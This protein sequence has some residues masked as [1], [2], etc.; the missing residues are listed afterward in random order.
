MAGSIKGIIVEIGGDTSG[1]QKALKQVN[2]TTS[3]LSK[4]LK[5]IN[6][7]LKLD[8]KNTE[9]LAQKQAVLSQNIQETTN[10]LN[11]LKQAQ[12]LADDTIKNG[13]T[14]SQEN[15]RNLQ[16]EIINTENKLKQLKV[17][18]SNWT[19]VSK[20][21]D[22]ISKKMKTV[23]DS[24]S[25]LGSS[26]TTG[27]TVPT[28]GLVG[29]ATAVGNKFEA[30]MSRV[31]SIAGATG[32][33]LKSL[34]DQALELGAQTSFSASEAAEGMENLASAGFTTKEIM[35]A[36][37][38]LLD[39]AA[40]SGS[41]L[42]TA[43]EI[44]ASAIR[45]F[46]LDASEAGHVADVFAEAAARTNAQTED[47][48]EAMKY[49]APVAHT[50]GIS[51]EETAAAIGIM[52]D[53]GIKGSQAGTSLR[54]ALTRLTKPTDK[55]LGVMEDLGISFY[56]N[57]GKM[58]SLTEMISMLQEATKGLTD[59]EKQ[60]A[61]TTLF[62]TES[63]SGM[64]ALI[65]RGPKE[66]SS[67]TDSFKGCDGAAS[68]MADT[69]LN[70]TSGAIEEMSGAI[71]TLAIKVQQILAPYIVAAANK[72]QE[73]VNKFINLPESTQKTILA[74]TGVAAAIGPVLLI[75]GKLISVGSTIF[76]VLSKVTSAIASVSA[77]TGTLSTVLTAITGPIGIVIGVI[78]ALGAAFVYLFNTNEQ[79]R[80]KAMEVWNSL[81]NLFKETI[82]PAFNT[83]KDA[84]MSALNTVWQLWQQLCEKLEP[85]VT[86]VLTW[87]MDF[88]NNTLKGI[89]ENVVNF[90]TKLIQG[91][92]EIYNNVI[93][94]IISAL[95]DVLWPVV[96]RVL[97]AIWSTISGVFDAIGGVIKAI[98]GIL[99][100]LITFITGVF[101]GDWKKAWQGISD[102]FKNI[103]EGLWSIIKTPLNWIIDGINGLINGINGI[104]IPD[105]VPG[106]GGKSL[107]IPTIPK[108]AKGG[109][110]DQ[111]TLAMVGEGKSAEAIIPLDRTL[112]RYM[113]EALKDAGANNNITVNFY[114]QQMTEAEL[115]NAF[116]Y[117]NRKFGLIY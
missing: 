76:G 102:I 10:K 72:I 59:E 12:K 6:S 117:I 23:G 20:S 36:M 1:L 78:T 39:L 114:P 91:W 54:G 19:A 79:F 112:T 2:T 101:T 48:G 50:M 22:N 42:A 37:P 26:L 115:D 55:M 40:S 38:G 104:K 116:N 56:D 33:E 70:N 65:S 111:A 113:S 90:I 85:F 66:L 35:E 17:E 68:E 92:T 13:G 44:A 83:I 41:E 95:V 94:P 31:Q 34:T 32:E 69:M 14:I 15:Y 28:L 97:N 100:G 51:L 18:A 3:N 88:W 110:V 87:L 82:I 4:E 93:A 108:L 106:V 73:L 96:E 24:I 11:Q 86:K 27:I 81:V 7:L 57:E 61:L 43:S 109:I 52:S 21:L 64:L 30:Q 107:S 67:M 9:L 105:W 47:M 58:K 63:L 89:I 74:I 53:A 45:G 49:I 25:G 99:D 77:G 29:A 84:V 75:I 8:P 16:R 71:E 62:G 60:N 5:G 103:V 46:G 98:T 80:N